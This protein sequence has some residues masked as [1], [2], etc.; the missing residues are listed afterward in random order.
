VVASIKSWL[1]HLHGPVVYVVIGLLVFFE[2]AIVIG[3][4]VPGEIATIIGGVIASQHHANVV[5]MIVVV[6]VAATVGNIV[7]YDVGRMLGPWLFSHRPLDGRDGVIRAQHL[8]A[9]RG[10]PAVVA[11]RFVVIVRAVLP[12]L[13]GMSGMLR[14]HFALFSAVGAAVWATLWVL[15]GFALGLSY[16]KVTNTFG[17]VTFVVVVA[18]V[19]VWLVVEVRRRRRRPQAP[20]GSGEHE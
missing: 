11:G 15:V 18:V 6:T 20:A 16:T 1:L 9:R 10:G 7:G 2:V 14:R 17:R 8:I 4:F 5:L 13:V 12:G 19:G 3:F